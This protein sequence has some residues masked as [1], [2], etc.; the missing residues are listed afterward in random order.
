MGNTRTP[1][2]KPPSPPEPAPAIVELKPPPE[3]GF[4]G[5]AKLLAETDAILIDELKRRG[6]TV[7]VEP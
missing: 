6:Y 3:T 4:S 5:T 7:V 2:P 1:S